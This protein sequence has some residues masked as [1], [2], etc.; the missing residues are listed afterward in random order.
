M[1]KMKRVRTLAVA[2]MV[3]ALSLSTLMSSASDF[4]ATEEESTAVETTAAPE[5]EPETPA[6][7]ETEPET[8]AAPETEP[9]TPAEPETEP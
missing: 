5:T 4:L 1:R 9:E 7:P 6:E 8:P 2:F 3:G